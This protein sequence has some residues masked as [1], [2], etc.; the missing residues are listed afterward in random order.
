MIPAEHVLGWLALLY[1]SSGLGFAVVSKSY[2]R[3]KSAMGIAAWCCALALVA[4]TVILAI[5]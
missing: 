2:P 5:W 4:A 1:W 3:I